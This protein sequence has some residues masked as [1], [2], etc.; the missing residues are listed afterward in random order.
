MLVIQNHP[1]EKLLLSYWDN[2]T[3]TTDGRSSRSLSLL[4]THEFAESCV[5]TSWATA[6]QPNFASR[7]AEL[8]S[9]SLSQ[10]YGFCR[11][12][13]ADTTFMTSGSNKKE[14]DSPDHLI[15]FPNHMDFIL[16]LPVK[17]SRF[18]SCTLENSRNAEMP[19]HHRQWS[20]GLEY[21]P[22]L[23]NHH[24]PFLRWSFSFLVLHRFIWQLSS[25]RFLS[26]H[27]R[28]A[29]PSV[30]RYPSLCGWKDHGFLLELLALK[31]PNESTKR[32]W[33]NWKKHSWEVLKIDICQNLH[34]TK[35]PP[36]LSTARGCGAACKN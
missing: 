5:K 1:K 4:G 34:I 9:T 14:P 13:S 28:C 36:E 12:V 21:D 30:F 35:I 17:N 31:K 20:G 10:T 25:L 7:T 3:G 24:P 6:S 8:P 19:T 32:H 18:M 29:P 15:T 22:N 23:L 33:K 2:T 27:L 11:Y 26:K 16:Y